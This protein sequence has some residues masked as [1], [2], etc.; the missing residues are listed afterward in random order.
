MDTFF[1][2][3]KFYESHVHFFYFFGS[4]AVKQF[5]YLIIMLKLCFHSIVSKN[6]IFSNSKRLCNGSGIDQKIIDYLSKFPNTYVQENSEKFWS[7]IWEQR[8]LFVNKD[9]EPKFRLLLPPPN[10][11]GSLHLGKLSKKNFEFDPNFVFFSQVIH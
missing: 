11:T 8:E 2:N 4:R 7:S 10:I 1:V 5:G 3:E 6:S 9:A